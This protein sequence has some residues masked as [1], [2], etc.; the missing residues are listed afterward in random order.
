LQA[1]RSPQLF[2]PSRRIPATFLLWCPC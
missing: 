1:F 2:H